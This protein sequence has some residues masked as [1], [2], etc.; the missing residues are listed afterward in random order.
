MRKM[1]DEIVCIE[2]IVDLQ[3]TYSVLDLKL[4]MLIEEIDKECKQGMIDILHF[5]ILLYAL[6][7]IPFKDEEKARQLY[8][9]LGECIE[10]ELFG[11]SKKWSIL[12]ILRKVQRL[13]K[14][15]LWDYIIN[16]SFTVFNDEIDWWE[17]K[18]D[19]VR[20][21]EIFHLFNMLEI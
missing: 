4:S 13:Q 6:R 3:A 11:R 19:I 21:E 12:R 14:Y 2:N 10:N 16:G 1:C 17:L 18:V 8:T 5:K 9:T 15:I 20:P 7:D